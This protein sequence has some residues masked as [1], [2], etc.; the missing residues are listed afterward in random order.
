MK[1]SMMM[2]AL[3]APM[4]ANASM[5]IRV[6]VQV[7]AMLKPDVLRG[8]LRFEEQGKNA[9]AIKEHLNAIIAEAKRIDPSGRYCHGGGYTLF[10]R[11]SY[12]DQKQ[13]FAGYSGNLSMNCEFLSIEQYNEMSD[14]IDKA[15]ASSVRKNQGAL[16][17]GVSSVQE[18]ETQ[19]RLRLELLRRVDGQ[20]KLFT[21][22][23]GMACEAVSV[24]FGENRGVNPIMTKGMAMM[25]SAPTENPIQ[26][27]EESAVEAVV[28]YACSNSKRVP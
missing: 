27:E 25:A 5:T 10:P 7:S 28:D 19:N 16:A 20:A 4:L 2:I 26:S 18:R 8:S 13:E 11:Y 24:N 6:N 22:E 3:L 23:T 12:I 9:N 17:W 14:A 1:K 21:K 15:T